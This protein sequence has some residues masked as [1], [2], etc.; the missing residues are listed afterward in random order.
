MDLLLTPEALALLR[1]PRT[2]QSFHVAGAEELEEWKALDDSAE[3]FLVTED[4][5]ISYPIEDGF[6]IILAERALE[7]PATPED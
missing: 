6:P 5:H 2:K 4:G 1:C 7:R 3:G